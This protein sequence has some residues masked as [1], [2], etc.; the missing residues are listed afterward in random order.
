[1]EY[2]NK[3]TDGNPAVGDIKGRPMEIAEVKVKKVH[4]IS[5]SDPIDQISDGAS[6]YQGKPGGKMRL[7]VGC[8]LIK[9]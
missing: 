9:I 6:K 3:N 5:K 7:A 1:M 8:F 4:N 2:E